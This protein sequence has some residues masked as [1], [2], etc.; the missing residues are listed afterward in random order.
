MIVE[1]K[2]WSDML[3]KLRLVLDR[4]RE[5]N[6]TL[7]P[8]KCL[9]S[10]ERVEFLGLVVENGRIRPGL[11]KTCA[12]AEYPTPTDVHA[13]RRFLGFTGFFRR[14]VV[15]YAAVAEPL[16]ILLRKDAVFKWSGEQEN[17]FRRLHEAIAGDAVQTMYHRDAEVTEQHTEAS[18]VGLRAV[19][20]QSWKRTDPLQMVYCA[21]LWTSETES[22][23]HFSKLELVCIVWAV[24]KLRQF[25][26][27][28]KFVILTD[29]QALVYLNNFKSQN[30][31]SH[32]FQFR[33]K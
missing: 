3:R 10:T 24:N 8:T 28:I 22:R 16:S 5:A 2:D 21:S 6:L 13:I 31:S 20:I 25:L 19:L 12:I 18:A 4:L 33:W 23:Y 11:E 14:F 17:A 27:K 32:I 30:A 26:L 29:C 9:F 1:G 7:K 15:G